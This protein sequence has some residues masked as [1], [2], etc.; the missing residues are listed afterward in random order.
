VFG[1]LVVN[2]GHAGVEHQAV[3]NTILGLGAAFAI[4]D[5]AW[6]IRGQVFLGRW[7][8][9][10]SVM[11][12]LF[13]G[14]LCYFLSGLESAFRYY[15]F[16]SLICCAIRYAPW[17]T[18]ATCGLHCASVAVLYLALPAAEQLPMAFWLTVVVMAWVTWASTALA[19]LLK[20][21][22]EHLE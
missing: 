13:I 4:L 22:G 9:L 21:F 12:A 16:L 19:M 8:L 20:R 2:V 7:P 3:L 14:L 18:Y 1:C 15:S 17:V 10:I 5:T 11:E 6:S